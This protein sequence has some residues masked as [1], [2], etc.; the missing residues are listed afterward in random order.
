MARASAPEIYKFFTNKQKRETLTDL[1][2]Q[3]EKLKSVH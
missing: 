3:R 1:L 2:T